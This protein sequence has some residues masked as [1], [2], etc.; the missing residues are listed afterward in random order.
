M[1]EI[2]RSERRVGMNSAIHYY[3]AAQRHANA[4]RDASRTL[5][6]QRS[7]EQPP[8]PAP[9]RARRLLLALGRG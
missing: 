9:R 2:A 7:I 5:P 8:V 3:S 4:L 1:E 6:Q